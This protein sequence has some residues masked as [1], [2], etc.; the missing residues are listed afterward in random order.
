VTKI[1]WEAVARGA[2]HPLRIRIIEKAAAAPNERFSPAELAA[3]FGEP[4]GNV[5]YHVRALVAE[6]LL[7][8]AGT[9]PRRGAIQHFY[10]ASQ[11]LMT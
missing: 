1:D 6:G 4:L 2:L 3:E 11:K 7:A 10:R 8:K 5:S 9:Q